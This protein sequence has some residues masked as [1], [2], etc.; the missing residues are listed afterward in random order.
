[1]EEY[2]KIIVV[3]ASA[4]V[5]AHIVLYLLRTTVKIVI[6]VVNKLRLKIRR[7]F[8]SRARKRR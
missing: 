8:R 1:M 2:I 6:G 4:I 3:L 7:Y 5:L